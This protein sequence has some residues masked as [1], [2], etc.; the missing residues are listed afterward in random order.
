MANSNTPTWEAPKF[1]F[2][3]DDKAAEWRQFYIKAIDYLEALDIDPDQ[4][5]ETKRGWKQFKMMFQ[6]DNRQTLQTLLDNNT[7]TAKDQG[8]TIQSTKSPYKLP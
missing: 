2:N 5:D 8:N 6:G 7:V 3:T 4:E 1:S